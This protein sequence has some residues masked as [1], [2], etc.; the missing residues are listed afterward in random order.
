MNFS[1][2]AIPQVI[3]ENGLLFLG[4]EKAEVVE[5]KIYYSG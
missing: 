1:F 5:G 4:R 3:S 2:D